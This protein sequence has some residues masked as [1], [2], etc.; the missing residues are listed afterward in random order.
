MEKINI[1]HRSAVG[2]VWLCGWLFTIG[3]LHVTFWRGVLALFVW[4]YYLGEA[5]RPLL[6]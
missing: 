5:L 1:E 3:F 2:L 4:P 6:R